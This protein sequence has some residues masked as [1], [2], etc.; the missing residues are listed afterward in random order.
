MIRRREINNNV[1]AR[2]DT[3]KL[4][5]VFIIFLT[6]RE[7]YGKLSEKKFFILYSSILDV[8]LSEHLYVMSVFVSWSWS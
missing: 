6:S 7:K 3:A 1:L 2:S 8:I 4:N 5:G